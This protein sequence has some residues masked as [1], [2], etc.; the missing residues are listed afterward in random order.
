MGRFRNPAC[1]VALATLLTSWSGLAQTYKEEIARAADATATGHGLEVGELRLGTASVGPHNL[2]LVVANLQDRP[3]EIKLVVS[4][5]PGLG[6]EYTTHEETETM[7]PSARQV[8]STSYALQR[9]TPFS[10]VTVVVETRPAETT[11][12][13]TWQS[14]FRSRAFLGIGNPAVS[15]DFPE[16]VRTSSRRIDAYF[17]PGSLAARDIDS[18][19]RLREDA[20]SRIDAILDTTFDGRIKLFLYPDEKVKFLH[21]GHRGM[22]WAYGDFIAEIYSED[23]KLDPVHELAHILSGQ[24][25]LL[26]AF[27]DEGFA[28]YISEAFGEDALEFVGNPGRSVDEVSAELVHSGRSLSIHDLLAVDNIGNTP[29]SAEVEYAQSASLVKFIMETYGPQSGGGLFRAFGPRGATP[30]QAEAIIESVLDLSMDRLIDDWTR[31][32]AD[33]IDDREK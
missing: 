8:L 4:V 21:T 28:T 9:L 27:L 13:D 19:L 31:A 10:R 11:G 17:L 1:V 15:R 20:I 7:A 3:C 12:E 22:G 14:V 6:D 23:R 26:P 5:F 16:L 18:I 33:T 24:L 25:G 2:Q 32:L 29:E 30:E